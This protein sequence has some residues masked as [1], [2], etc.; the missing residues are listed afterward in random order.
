MAGL[1]SPEV[2]MSILPRGFPTEQAFSDEDVKSSM[3]W[4][5]A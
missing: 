4:H 1:P 5:Q 2:R 3:M